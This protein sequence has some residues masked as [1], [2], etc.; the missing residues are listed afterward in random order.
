MVRAA[1]PFD[2]A[3]DQTAW[4]PQMTT[5]G[6]LAVVATIWYVGSLNLL[7]RVGASTRIGTD[8]GGARGMRVAQSITD[9]PTHPFTNQRQ[10]KNLV[11]ID[12]RS[13]VCYTESSV[14]QRSH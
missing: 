8:A 4:D 3:E 9:N 2:P 14:A 13:G 7:Q 1:I 5:I 11:Y 6:A 10:S 12:D